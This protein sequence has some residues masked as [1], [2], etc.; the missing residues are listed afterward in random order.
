[1]MIYIYV[2]TEMHENNNKKKPMLECGCHLW[3]NDVM[4]D[5]KSHLAYTESSWV[6]QISGAYLLKSMVL[7]SDKT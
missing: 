7:H 1:M 3:A 6:F 5:L 4:M 2:I